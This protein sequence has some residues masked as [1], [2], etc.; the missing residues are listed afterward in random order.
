MGGR[1]CPYR[2]ARLDPGE[3]CD[4]HYID[5]V[6]LKADGVVEMMRIRNELSALQELVGG[7]I[8]HVDFI[9]E[10]GILCDEDGR[11]KGL[12]DNVYIPYIAGDVVLIGEP[13]D[14]GDEFRSLTNK[15]VMWL[16]SM[17]GKD[18]K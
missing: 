10:I 12:P 11:S 4:C 14:G 16:F 15:E 1:E 5:V 13:M 3:R 7:Y 9:P 6:V 2:G 8:E 17:A 18:R